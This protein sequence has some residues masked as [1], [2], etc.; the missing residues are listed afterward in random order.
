MPV[1]GRGIFAGRVIIWLPPTPILG[2]ERVPVNPLE[3]AF[4]CCVCQPNPE[5]DLSELVNQK[6]ILD[7]RL[8]CSTRD[9]RKIPVAALRV[10][11]RRRPVPWSSRQRV[12]MIIAACRRRPL[13]PLPGVA[14]LVVVVGEP[15]DRHGYFRAVE[16]VVTV[17]TKSDPG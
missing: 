2:G 4:D 12:V 14:G 8:L 15:G 1:D 17:R 7:E 11:L 13:D 16:A 9:R 6:R 10:I 5:R 3:R